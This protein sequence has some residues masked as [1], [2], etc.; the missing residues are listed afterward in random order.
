MIGATL[1]LQQT[2]P[3]LHSNPGWDP[4]VSRPGGESGTQ[5]GHSLFLTHTALASPGQLKVF[6][7][8]SFFK[9]VGVESHPRFP[10]LG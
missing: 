10:L 2:C 5:V 8:S 7:C 3:P 9:V 4:R 1:I 6:V